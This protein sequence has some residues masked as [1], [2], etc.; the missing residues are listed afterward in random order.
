MPASMAA[1]MIAELVDSSA[2]NPKLMVPRPIR[3]TSRPERPTC[4]YA[5]SSL[6]AEAYVAGCSHGSSPGDDELARDSARSE[7]SRLLVLDEGEHL[8]D[9][10]LRGAAVRGCGDSAGPWRYLPRRE[11]RRRR[12]GQQKRRFVVGKLQANRRRLVGAA[13]APARR[14]VPA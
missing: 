7:R 10:E 14:S 4:A 9:I 12:G 3:L 13:G 5:I 11:L 2:V 8:V 1:S 6:T